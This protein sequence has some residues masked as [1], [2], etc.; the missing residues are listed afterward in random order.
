MQSLDD[1]EKAS[2]ERDFMRAVMKGIGEIEDG[3][4][5]SMQEVEVG[6]SHRK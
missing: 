5:I 1:F 2:E 6:L 3:R 4:A